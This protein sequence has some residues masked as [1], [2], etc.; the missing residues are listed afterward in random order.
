MYEKHSKSDSAVSF[1]TSMVSVRGF[2]KTKN[3]L[4]WD[5]ISWEEVTYSKVVTKQTRRKID[6][7][8]FLQRQP[9]TLSLPWWVKRDNA[10]HP[11]RKT[12]IGL[13]EWITRR[14]NQQNKSRT[15]SKKYAVG[16][17]STLSIRWLSKVAKKRG[18]FCGFSTKYDAN[19][20]KLSLLVW[21]LLLILEILEIGKDCFRS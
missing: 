21:H 11:R 7:R 6:F 19:N 14:Q 5:N 13:N 18:T 20:T 4:Y 1:F 15:V 2:N 10:T 12:L 17:I 16:L 9:R 3:H 8:Y